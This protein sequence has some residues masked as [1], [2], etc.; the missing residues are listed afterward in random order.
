MVVCGLS[1]R[2]GFHLAAVHG[3]NS[4]LQCARVQYRGLGAANRHR[5][6]VY[7]VLHRPL[8]FIVDDTVIGGNVLLEAPC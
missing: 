6:P 4:Q 3:S 8:I 7:L 1:L 5:R 2:L